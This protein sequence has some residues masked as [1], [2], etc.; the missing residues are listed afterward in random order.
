M[1]DMGG[2]DMT[3]TT[4][5]GYL[6]AILVFSSFYMK[7]MIPL[8][9]TAIA[10]NFI[11]VIYGYYAGITPMLILHLLLFPLNISRLIQ[12][13]RLIQEVDEAS[14]GDLS[15]DWLLPFTSRKDFR[16]GDVIAKKGDLADEVYFILKGKVRLEE[17]HVSVGEGEIIGEIGVFAPGEKRSSTLICETDLETLTV[18]GSTVKELYYQNPKLGFYLTQLIIGRLLQNLELSRVKADEGAQAS[19]SL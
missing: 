18:S 1:I 4:A 16:K 17:I 13:K 2:M 14:Q 7:T 3:W 8:R 19:A 6:A 12:M 5:L 10:S 15:M 9:Y 11:Y